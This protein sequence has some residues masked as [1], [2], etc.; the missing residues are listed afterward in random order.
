MQ[1]PT[2]STEHSGVD[3]LVLDRGALASAEAFGDARQLTAGGM[4]E[5]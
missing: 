4:S 1:D 5:R 2:L 3:G